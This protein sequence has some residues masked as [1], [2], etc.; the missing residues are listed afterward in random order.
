MVL[1]VTGIAGGQPSGSAVVLVRA[2]LQAAVDPQQDS[3]L[4]RARIP[5][6]G[7]RRLGEVDASSNIRNR[8]IGQHDVAPF[9]SGPWSPCL[10][11][12]FGHSTAKLTIVQRVDAAHS[13]VF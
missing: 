9:L 5:G 3:L 10:P 11:P 12:R 6:V 1:Q 4:S 13:V 7:G 2:L 8:R